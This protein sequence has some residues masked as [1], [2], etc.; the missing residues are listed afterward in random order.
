MTPKTRSLSTQ[1]SASCLPPLRISP[2]W[3]FLNILPPRITLP[4]LGAPTNLDLTTYHRT[5]NYAATAAKLLQS[6]PILCSPIDGSPPGSPVPGILQGRT[7]EW[8]LNYATICK[9]QDSLTVLRA[10][11]RH[12]STGTFT[13]MIVMFKRTLVGQDYVSPLIA[14]EVKGL[15]D[16]QATVEWA[17]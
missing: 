17:G 12:Q 15:A 8:V 16:G 10:P 5:L 2:S 1:P 6:C 14:E 3:T 7:L 13:Y 11:T 9:S 4:A